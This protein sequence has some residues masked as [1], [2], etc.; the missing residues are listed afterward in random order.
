MLWIIG[1]EV[2]V[3]DLAKWLNWPQLKLVSGQ[4]EHVNWDGLQAYDLI[5]P[6]F[7]FLSGVAIP[8]SLGNRIDRGDSRWH[9]WGKI[10][11]R[12]CVFILLGV[13]YNGAL[14]TSSEVPRI[15]SVLG[16]IGIAWGIAASLYLVVSSGGKRIGI[17]FGLLGFIAML[18]ILV[19]VPG[20]GPGVLTE[21]GA[22]NTWLDRLFLPGKLNGRTFDPEGL[23]CILSAVALP[24]AGSLVGDPLRSAAGITWK[25]VGIQFLTGIGFIAAGWLCWRMGYPPVKALWT[26]TFN[27]FAIGI[28]LTL[29]TMFFAVIDVAGVGFWSFP[30]RVIGM[31]SLTIYLG[32]RLINFSAPSEFLFGRLS[33]LAGDAGPLVLACGVVV[34]E[35]LALW[36]FYQKKW[37]L[38]V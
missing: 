14:S 7:M 10:F 4:L 35:W 25:R 9:L 27:L 13:V 6:L 26:T 20:Y 23:L 15:A 16:Q 5:F 29:F 37:F 30:L 38:R 28:S 1:A 22:I 21:T 11:I 34:L 32:H 2:I 36:F 8:F 24:L 3:R 17:L 19:P 12:I 33:R 18:Q 31:N